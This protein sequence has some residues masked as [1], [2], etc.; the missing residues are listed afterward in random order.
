MSSS[1]QGKADGSHDLIAWFESFPL[2][3]ITLLQ[4]SLDDLASPRFK[5]NSQLRKWMSQFFLER[6]K[7]PAETSGV[8][9]NEWM[10]ERKIVIVRKN[11]SLKDNQNS[12]QQD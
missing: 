11:K 7:E 12:S 9:K 6:R 3:L 4:S 10:D 8:K 1:Q 5:P 2:I